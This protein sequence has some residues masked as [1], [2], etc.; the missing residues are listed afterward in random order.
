[1]PEPTT[2]PGKHSPQLAA[3][4]SSGSAAQ[5]PCR[6]G[7]ADAKGR[8]ARTPATTARGPAARHQGAARRSRTPRSPRH[9]RR[10]DP[11]V[12]A[13]RRE[14]HRRALRTAAPAR[15]GDQSRPRPLMPAQLL[16]ITPSPKPFMSSAPSDHASNSRP[17][18]MSKSVG[19]SSSGPVRYPSPIERTA[20]VTGTAPAAPHKAP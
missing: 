7:A 13:R 3:S 16:L 18:R 9:P 5:R 8:G 15:P 19:M 4:R 20:A 14:L 10:L 11:R 1:M 17:P 2:R 12:A 6:A